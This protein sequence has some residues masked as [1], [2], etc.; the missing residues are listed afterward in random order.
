MSDNLMR[1][2]AWGVAVALVMLVL[3]SADV[4]GVA[5]SAIVFDAARVVGVFFAATAVF[6]TRGP[7]EAE[8]A[9][10]TEE[11]YAHYGDVPLDNRG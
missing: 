2:W 5:A 4:F 10:M 8:I 3:A 9:A 1:L 7:S 6:R 11:I